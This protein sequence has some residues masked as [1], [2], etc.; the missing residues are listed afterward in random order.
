[1]L[2]YQL[3][4]DILIDMK[5]KS[6]KQREWKKGEV[7]LLRVDANVPLEN[8]AVAATADYRL[9]RLKPTIDF[10][11]S[12]E[13]RIVLIT[14]LGR[15]ESRWSLVNDVWSLTP[16]DQESFTLEPV[17]ERLSA[18]LGADIPLLHD[19]IGT[20][21]LIDHIHSYAPS[22]VVCL[23]NIRYYA[24]EEKNET[25][26]A[27]TL[28]SVGSVFVND[29][30]G[31]CHRKAASVVGV[32]QFLESYAGFLLME[33]VR[34]L[35][36]VREKPE[37]PFIA[38]VGGA[39]ISTK[40]GLLSRLLQQANTVL[41]GGGLATTIWG[42]L[43]YGVGGSLVEEDQYH[44]V[45]RALL[46][47]YPAKLVLPI[48]VVVRSKTTDTVRVT[49][50]PSAPTA[51]CAGDEEIV[52]AGPATGELVK[53]IM[54]EHTLAVWNGTFGRAEDPRFRAGSKAILEALAPV[55]K[56]IVG[57]GETVM[58]VQE[59]KAAKQF[60]FV[61][62]GGGAMLEFLEGKTLPGIE[63]LRK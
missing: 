23:E 1:M 22:D 7:V 58:F 45:N 48:D 19:P 54:N 15:P 63:V 31:V 30:F 49:S 26:F 60:S 4:S 35:G 12:I 56:T 47:R 13:A 61:S 50:V 24:G 38:I 6:L 3:H 59:E 21:E 41:V 44:E 16:A 62:T 27:R 53:K 9:R 20:K 39:K 5:L 46:Q 2:S 10:L 29:A 14:H 36:E 40:M 33:E 28:A 51:L 43:G 11:R 37:R 32:T 18:L 17:V 57:G 25:N 8:G 42:A 34:R 55:S 52:D